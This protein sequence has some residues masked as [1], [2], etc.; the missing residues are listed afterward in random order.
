L[1]PTPPSCTP[2]PPPST[3]PDDHRG[4]VRRP[5]RGQQV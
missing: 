4:G 2:W 3:S 1:A 5:C